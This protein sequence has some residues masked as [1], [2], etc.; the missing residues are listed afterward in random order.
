MAQAIIIFARNWGR[1]RV[2]Y[3]NLQW[4]AVNRWK[5]RFL[6]YLRAIEAE[7]GFFTQ[8]SGEASLTVQK[9]G[10]LGICAIGTVPLQSYSLA[11]GW[12]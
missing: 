5:T 10:F 4:S 12:Q 2:F 8:I 6:D 1:N 7:T 3:P 9:P 11:L